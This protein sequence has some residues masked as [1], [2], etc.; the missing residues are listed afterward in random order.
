MQRTKLQKIVAAYERFGAD[1]A[2]VSD[3]WAQQLHR[4]SSGVAGSV[5]VLLAKDGAPKSSQVASGLEQGLRETPDIIAAVSAQWRPAV[6]QAFRNAIAAEYPDFFSKDSQRLDKILTRGH[7][8]TESEFYLVRHFVD[9]LEDELDSATRVS[10]LYAML[11][12]YQRIDLPTDIDASS[13]T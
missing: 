10:Q 5:S 2:D 6:A 11:D 13:R 8:K 1:I 9:A 12:A 4:T 3:Q 7:I